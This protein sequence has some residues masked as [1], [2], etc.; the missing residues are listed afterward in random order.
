[1]N[2][3]SWKV[4]D[5]CWFLDTKADGARVL[6]ETSIVGVQDFEQAGP[7]ISIAE[8]ASM[9]SL[10]APLY[11]ERGEVIALVGGTLIPGMRAATWRDGISH[12]SLAMGLNSMAVPIAALG[13]VTAVSGTRLQQLGARGVFV[14]PLVGPRNVLTGTIA[15]RVEKR[16]EVPMPVDEKREFA[17]REGE[18][19][20][21]LTFDPQEKREGMA[22][23]KI[24]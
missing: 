16:N 22:V 21:F 10:G 11:N 18:A 12:V 3:P 1:E 4:G 9:S 15:R 7:R 20:A 19:V 2:A 14:P 17:R 5:R 6:V 23:F 24:F 13:E 8:A